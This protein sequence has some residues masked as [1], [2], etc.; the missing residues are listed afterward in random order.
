MLDHMIL[1]AAIRDTM[2]DA[3]RAPTVPVFRNQ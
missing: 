3:L 2:L 1:T